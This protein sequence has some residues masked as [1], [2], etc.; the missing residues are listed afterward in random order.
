LDRAQSLAFA[1]L[2]GDGHQARSSQR[3]K[4]DLIAAYCRRR[5]AVDA[6]GWS[7]ADRPEN[8]SLRAADQPSRRMILARKAVIDHGGGRPGKIEPNFPIA[9][10]YLMLEVVIEKRRLLLTHPRHSNEDAG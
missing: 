9:D 6:K 2:W 4:T 3:K 5:I 10:L 7:A 1:K 8:E